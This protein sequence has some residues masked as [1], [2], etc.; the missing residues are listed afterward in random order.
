VSRQVM[1]S[2]PAN[3]GRRSRDDDDLFGKGSGHCALRLVS[4]GVSLA[5]RGNSERASL[6]T[7]DR[8]TRV[9]FGVP[10]N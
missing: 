7:D 2:L 3:P 6:A 9:A 4:I 5:T 1:R 10:L 8:A